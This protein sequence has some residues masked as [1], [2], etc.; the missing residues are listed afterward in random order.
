[1][2][3][4]VLARQRFPEEALPGLYLSASRTAQAAAQVAATRFLSF[5]YNLAAL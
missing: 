4:A 2:L 1:L 5:A 3:R